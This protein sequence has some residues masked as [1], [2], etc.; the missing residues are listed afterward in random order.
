MNK[1]NKCFVYG[2]MF[3]FGAIILYLTCLSTY[4]TSWMHGYEDTAFL[5]DSVIKNIIAVLIVM[6]AV[7]LFKYKKISIS[8]K[9]I[10]YYAI[11]VNIFWVWFVLSTQFV[12]VDDQGAVLNVA[13][14][15]IRGNYESWNVGSYAA[16][17]SN[18]NGIILIYSVLSFI[19]GANNEVAFQLLNVLFI[20]GTFYY[21]S[22]FF[23]RVMLSDHIGKLIF[24]ILY[25]F[26]PYLLYVTFV[27]GTVIGLF[28]ATGAIYHTLLFLEK[29]DWKN[30]M[31]SAVMIGMATVCK[32]NYYIYLIAVGIVIMADVLSGGKDYF[33]TGAKKLILLAVMILLCC[34]GKITTT[35]VIEQTTG[36]KVNGTPAILWVVMGLQEGW[37]APGWNNTFNY[38][39]F[40]DCEYDRDYA[41][42]IGKIWL[43]QEVNKFVGDHNYAKKFFTEKI[44]SIW[45]N[46][47]FECFEVQKKRLA[48]TG[49]PAMISDMLEM[50]H[51]LNTAIIHLLDAYLTIIYF[52]VLLYCILRF[53]KASFRELTFALVFVGIF[54]FH[55]VWEA[56]CY[57][58]VP[59]MVMLM[60]YMVLGYSE[61]ADKLL[62]I[63]K[64][65]LSV[66]KWLNGNNVL[67]LILILFLLYLYNRYSYK[68]ISTAGEKDKYNAAL[69]ESAYSTKMNNTGYYFSAYEN[70]NLLLDLQDA[71]DGIRLTISERN[72]EKTQIFEL[73]SEFLM[74]GENYYFITNRSNEQI[75]YLRDEA[76]MSGNFV[77]L[78]EVSSENKNLCRVERMG[79]YFYIRNYYGLALTYDLTYHGVYWM[80]FDDAENQRWELTAA[81]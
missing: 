65:K 78:Q 76:E 9:F 4:M 41:K 46:P 40:R 42:E 69:E 6:S 67:I 14:A 58:T 43:A 77:Y 21:I 51:P 28:F 33:K 31:S 74:T 48:Q 80:P 71:E 7:C 15:F 55:I 36:K 66:K 60:P 39:Q 45:T 68:Y 53:K 22:S 29:P 81:D 73:Q 32:S 49:V 23:R 26:L 2:L 64:E 5:K 34:I 17:W 11:A 62:K 8:D 79:D 75:L 52:G 13:S 37:K 18:Q 1:T 10:K 38:W 12:C 25:T 61:S 63:K 16:R 56:R 47:T 54:L 19:F 57:Y 3:I 24:V 27:Y 70:K 35:E 44:A 72:G 59:A 30:G 50:G 20:F